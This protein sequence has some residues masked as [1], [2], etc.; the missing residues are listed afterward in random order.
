ME[1]KIL[2]YFDLALILA[3]FERGEC[4]NYTRLLGKIKDQTWQYIS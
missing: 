3:L 4:F 1:K 2:A